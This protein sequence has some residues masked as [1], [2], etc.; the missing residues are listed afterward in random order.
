MIV[1]LF[2]IFCETGHLQAYHA[3][4]VCKDITLLEVCQSYV[5]A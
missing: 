3:H 2:S 5:Y 4:L 1:T